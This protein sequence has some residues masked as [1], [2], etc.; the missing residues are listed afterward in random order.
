MKKRF[1]KSNRGGLWKAIDGKIL[2]VSARY[3]DVAARLSISVTAILVQSDT[4]LVLDPWP[5]PQAQATGMWHVPSPRLC[6]GRVKWELH[7][8]RT[9]PRKAMRCETTAIIR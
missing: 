6:L 8:F 7:G 2:E 4:W 5:K 9:W 1:A 3:G